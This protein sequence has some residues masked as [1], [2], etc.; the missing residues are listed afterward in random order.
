M[1]HEELGLE[2]DKQKKKSKTAN[3]TIQLL[4]KVQ[5]AESIKQKEQSVPPANFRNGE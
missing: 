5:I 3:A 2:I 4:E 1:N